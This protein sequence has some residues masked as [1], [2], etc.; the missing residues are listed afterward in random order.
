MA[1]SLPQ[2]QTTTRLTAWL[3]PFTRRP[4]SASVYGGWLLS[5]YLGLAPVYVLPGIE[6]EHLRLAKGLLLAAALALTLLPPLLAGRL[7]LPGGLLGPLGFL[8]LLLLSV[9][10]MA[11]AREL[12]LVWM[13]L[14]D[15]GLGAA[16]LWCFFWLARQGEDV[17][18]IL[19]RGLVII[20][21]FAAAAVVVVL[22]RI[23]DWGSPCGEF[24]R[25]L[26][27]SGFATARTV[28]SISL[29]LFL[30]LAV[31]LRQRTRERGALLALALSV[32]AG[33]GIL[34]S[35][36]IS[37]GR[38][39]ILASLIVLAGLL[40]AGA[41][42]WLAVGLAG[43]LAL[44]GVALI[45]DTCRS[46]LQRDPAVQ[47]PEFSGPRIVEQ[48]DTFSTDRVTGYITGLEKTAVRPFLGHG[49]GQVRIKGRWKPFIEIH[50]LWLK[51]AVYCGVLAPL[52]FAAMA[53]WVLWMAWRLLAGE[54]AAESRAAVAALTLIVV[55]GLAASMIEPDALIGAFQFTAVWWAAAGILAG[56]YARR[57]RRADWRVPFPV[58]RR[59]RKGG[60]E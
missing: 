28:W 3:P 27:N 35:Q 24:W 38:G 58:L 5:L 34:V 26:Y 31:L 16:F 56:L 37:G 53:A 36:F 50:N 11:Q 20:A 1:E 41:S 14:L 22:F 4:F 47:S 17:Y 19:L 7:R 13:F 32:A 18:L 57:R 40:L 60:A 46:H 42:R 2:N 44:I 55:A 51:W 9:P 29:A 8:G 30:P 10:G 25:P 12:S 21:A 54:G 45:D 59:R 15:I 52:L 48:L 33:A 43:V 6:Y 39:G 49:L 23:P